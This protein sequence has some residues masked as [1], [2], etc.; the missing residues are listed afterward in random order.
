VGAQISSLRGMQAGSLR[1]VSKAWVASGSG[2][3]RSRASRGK[4]AAR[5][6]P[7]EIPATEK[8]KRGPVRVGDGTTARFG[9]NERD[10]SQKRR[11]GEPGRL[12]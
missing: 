7:Y 2:R 4:G 6:R 11:P 10:G 9:R 12:E 3:K 1:Y 8:A 5:L